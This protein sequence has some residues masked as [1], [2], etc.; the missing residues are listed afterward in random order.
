MQQVRIEIECQTGG[1]YRLVRIA[2]AAPNLNQQRVQVGAAHC[3]CCC[4]LVFVRFYA[5][6]MHHRLRDAGM[7]QP[8]PV[9]Y[10]CS[11][12]CRTKH[13]SWPES[14]VS[15]KIHSFYDTNGG[16]SLFCF[17]HIYFPASGQG[18]VIG[19]VPSSPRSLRFLPSIF[20]AH[21]V[22]QSRC[23]SMFHRVL[24][25]HALA[26]SASQF[27]HKKKSPRMYTSMHS[28][29]FELTKLTNTRVEDDLIRHR[30]DRW[31]QMIGSLVLI[32]R[33]QRKRLS[34]LIHQMTAVQS[35]GSLSRISISCC[36]S[37][38]GADLQDL[39]SQRPV[40]ITAVVIERVW[41]CCH[42]YDR[43]CKR[44]AAVLYL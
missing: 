4:G 2:R 37:F 16:L 12:I 40:Y 33:S 13:S 20:I 39:R 3:C 36:T 10:C 8:L 27:V 7:I 1:T 31:Y 38:N 21:R 15:Q 26:L 32:H 28:G 35:H 9:P 23:S 24:L 29:G 18:V 19:V 11:M 30:G 25:T 41:S 44:S 17:T 42:G 22:Q 43:G 5:Y 34:R 14:S 6:G